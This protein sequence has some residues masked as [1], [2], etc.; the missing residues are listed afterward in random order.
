M[1]KQKGC[2]CSKLHRDRK[3]KNSVNSVNSVE[4]NPCAP[5]KESPKCDAI[6]QAFGISGVGFLKEIQRE[7]Q[8]ERP[9]MRSKCRKS[10][11]FTI[12]IFER[13][14]KVSKVVFGKE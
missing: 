4:Q 12:A 6:N 9:K 1:K 13:F 10:P 3:V 11:A 14:T 2:R 7:N 8:H 5:K